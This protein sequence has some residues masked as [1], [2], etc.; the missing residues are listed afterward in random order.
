[1]RFGPWYPL[2]DTDRHAPG[3]PGILQ[4]RLAAGL[5]GYPTG[6]SAMVHYELCDDVAA[7]AA[8]LAARHP[9]RPWLCRHTIELTARDVAGLAPCFAGLV[10][11]FRARFGAAPGAAEVLA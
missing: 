5:V 4:V 6:R 7:A 2:T 3:G 11:R 1:M 10:D 9:G 8:R